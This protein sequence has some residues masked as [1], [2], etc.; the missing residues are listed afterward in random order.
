MFEGRHGQSLPTEYFTHN[1][2][3]TRVGVE[4]TTTDIKEDNNNNATVISISS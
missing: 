1:I 3:L 2:G 4:D